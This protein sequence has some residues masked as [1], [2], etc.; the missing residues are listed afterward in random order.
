MRN[1]HSITNGL[2]RRYY[3]RD[4][5][6]YCHAILKT[7]PVELDESSGVVVL[8]Q[9]YH[10]DLLMFLVAAKSFA[11]YLH[12]TKF[13]VVDD[14]FTAEDQALI[15][16]HL[17]SVD[18]IARKS[19]RSQSCPIG[20]CW[21]RLLSIADFCGEN[22]VIQLDSDTVT[23][24]EPIEVKAHISRGAS[25]TL[26]TKQGRAFVPVAQA[27]ALVSG[28]DSQHI[29]VL[30]EKALAEIEAVERDEYIRGCAGFAGFAMGSM[31]R[32][33]V[34]RISSFMVEA[35]GAEV[36]KRWG[37]EQFASNYLIANTPKKD[38]LAFENYP[39]W[40]LGANINQAR[41]I[42]FIGDSRFTS[43][44]YRRIAIEAIKKLSR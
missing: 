33:S 42:H 24:S 12:P 15:R 10:K 31:T 8:S 43:Y 39:Y 11:S 5:D 35:L 38:L 44:S 3:R 2:K 41:L 4:F 26:S 16:H 17:K 40:E 9:S 32:G 20:G 21:E 1:I 7:R 28:N 29:Q 13:V 23:V 27:A 18:F 34:E 22:Y 36:W 19:V 6:W 30:A 25:F 37:S 14:G